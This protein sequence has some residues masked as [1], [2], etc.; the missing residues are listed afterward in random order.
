M[1]QAQAADQNQHAW[2]RYNT[3]NLIW[4]DLVALIDARI[5]LALDAARA[6]DLEQYVRGRRDG[7]NGVPQPLDVEGGAVQPESAVADGSLGSKLGDA[8]GQL[9]HDLA[10][11]RSGEGS[12]GASPVPGME[13]G[14]GDTT[15]S[16]L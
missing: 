15:G 12:V 7:S 10:P 8:V 14:T 5:E 11:S 16:A 6:R 9:A 4:D 2:E 3:L 13:T 1:P